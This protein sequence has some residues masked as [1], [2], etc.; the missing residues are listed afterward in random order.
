MTTATHSTSEVRS[1][2]EAYLRDHEAFYLDLLRHM[3]NIN[4][5][6]AHREGVNALGEL[7][8]A[9]FERLGFVA[10][11]VDAADPSFAHHLVLTRLGRSG[12]SGKKR[13]PKVGLVSHLD[14]VYPPEE[15]ELHDFAWRPEGD[16]LFGPG[17]V[18]IKGGT[19]VAYMM[20]D[21]LR[22]VVPDVFEET[23]WVFALDSAEEQLADDFGP[24]CLDR[25]GDAVAALVFEG[26]SNENLGDSVV[27]ARKGMAIF[28]IVAK[29]RSAHSGNKLAHG[30]NAL[31]QM[32]EVIQRIDG[33]VELDRGLTW[34]VGV[35]QGGTVSNR[36]PHHAFAEVEMRT[37]SAED[38]DRSMKNALGLR[39]L[40][41]V[42]SLEDGY[43]CTVEVE[44]LTEL[45]PWPRNPATDRL[46]AIWQETA[47]ELGR[48]L[49]FEERGGLSDGNRFWHDIPTLDGL[50]PAGA[51]A[52]CSER[53]GDGA[54]EQEYAR[55]SSLVPK[56]HLNTCAVLKLLAETGA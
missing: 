11:T 19:V 31:L 34:N 39:E 55:R 40:S 17:T 54:K 14:T 45:E 52:H 10:E 18:D 29:G 49:V 44:V 1:Q 56:A 47:G 23:S 22:A 30:A 9:T 4:S 42:K 28:H 26:S 5:F 6:T 3:V 43:P 21:A 24:L 36:V 15:E 50:G 35:A 27:V 20:L 48:E 13:A 2:I 12:G 51:H 32:A 53:S 16:R 38:F 37:F 25:F 33:W 7:T 8:A 46:A 41:T